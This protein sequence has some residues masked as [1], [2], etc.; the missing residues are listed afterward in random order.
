M[1]FWK[2]KKADKVKKAKDG[3]Q[4]KK[5]LAI[6]KDAME[7]ASTVENQDTEQQEC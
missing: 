2:I 1:F 7:V 3:E 5:D 4:I 6:S